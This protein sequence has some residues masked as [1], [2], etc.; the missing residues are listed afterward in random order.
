M[1]NSMAPGLKSAR[2]V[3]PKPNTA[4]DIEYPLPLL[5]YNAK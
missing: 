2:Q 1:E 3:P 4:E 5:I